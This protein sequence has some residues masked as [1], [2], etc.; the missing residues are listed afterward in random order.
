MLQVDGVGP[1]RKGKGV[2]RL[3]YENVNG[4]SNKLSDNEK[5]EKAK[6]IDNK[7]E[8]DI[9]AYNDRRLS[10]HDRRNINGFNQLFKRG[11]ATL[12]SVVALNV[13][14]NIGRVQE[15]RISLLLFGPLTEQLDNDQPGKDESGLGCW[16]VMMLQG[17][18]VQTRVVCGYNLCYNKNQFS[19]TTYQHTAAKTV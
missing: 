11:E 9:V 3:I 12:Q 16:F 8:V 17:N 6:E 18:R 19:S 10:M 15:G 13:H 2:I 4:L 1:Q 5:V 14:E 7:L